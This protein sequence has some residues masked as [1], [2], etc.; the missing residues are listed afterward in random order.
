VASYSQVPRPPLLK[1]LF[2]D[3]VVERIAS[4]RRY[5]SNRSLHGT[6]GTVHARN[7]CIGLSGG[8][9]VRQHSCVEDTALHGDP[10]QC[11]ECC[12]LPWYVRCQRMSARAISPTANLTG[13][14]TQPRA[15]AQIR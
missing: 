2:V 7:S 8:L 9:C 13:M 6:R 5:E 3:Q 4:I 12:S 1:R 10:V 11:R 14:M 15:T